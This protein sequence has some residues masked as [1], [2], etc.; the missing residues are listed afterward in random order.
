MILCHDD[1]PCEE[2]LDQNG[3]CPMCGF[4]PDTQSTCY[5]TK[6]DIWLNRKHDEIAVAIKDFAI[7]MRGDCHI[8]AHEKGKAMNKLLLEVLHTDS[9]KDYERAG[10]LFSA[11]REAVMGL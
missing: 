9:A 8:N 7:S 5:R 3:M 11:F 4:V 10:L 6:D 1:P 2:P